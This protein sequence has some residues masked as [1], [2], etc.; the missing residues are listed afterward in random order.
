[1]GFLRSFKGRIIFS[2][3]LLVAV[4][5]GVSNFLE[6]QKLSN[7]MYIQNNDAMSLLVKESAQKVKTW[8]STFKYALQKSAPGFAEDRSEE[9]RLLMVKQISLVS[10]ATSVIVAYT[11]GSVLGRKGA[12]AVDPRT[13]VWYK[14]AQQAGKG[15]V[16]NVYTDAFTGKKLVSIAEPFYLNGVFKG[17]LL[18]DIELD[19]VNVMLKRS[20]PE[21]GEL[22]LY[23]QSGITIASTTANGREYN[24]N[25][26]PELNSLERAIDRNKV[27]SLEYVYQNM[28]A[29]SYFETISL[30]DDINWV[31]V[32]TADKDIIFS[33]LKSALNESIITAIALIVVSIGILILLLNRFYR[34]ILSL[35][36]TIG[37]LGQGNADLTRRLV[38]SNNKDDLDDIAISVNQFV[39]VIP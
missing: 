32:I 15:I 19:A 1:M 36:E 7:E 8:I 21:T 39:C 14:K 34:P 5:L 2:S 18:A 9:S 35:K 33:N 17:V 12:S 16:T 27:G 4:S 22:A 31:I 37:A 24:L 29:I 28:N 25:S 10:H 30:S 23:A 20:K 26:D 38:I 3:A 6:N 11:D 13:R